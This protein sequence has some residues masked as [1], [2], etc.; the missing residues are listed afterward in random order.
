MK[1]AFLVKDESRS[2][3]HYVN[4]FDPSKNWTISLP[5]ECRDIQWLGNGRILVS[6]PHGYLEYDLITR[7]EVKS[8][9]PKGC[10]QVESAIRLPDGRTVLG[11]RKGHVTFYE[12]APD[13]NVLR[14][15]DFKNYHDLRLFRFSP[16]GHFLF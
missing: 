2:K 5:K 13:D 1:H 7:K 10:A 8:V 3:L 9:F 14:R 6:H 11:G 15:V 12:L 4:Q 16:E